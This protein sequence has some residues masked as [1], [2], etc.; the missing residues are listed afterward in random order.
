MHITP[1][2]KTP[3]VVKDVRG[4]YT[5]RVFPPYANEAMLMVAEGVKSAPTVAALGE[6]YG[7]EMPITGDV[8]SVLKGEQSPRQ[9]CRGLLKSSVGAESEPG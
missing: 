2:H 7:V 6:Q 8:L 4:F 5:N 1:K 3:I 9:A